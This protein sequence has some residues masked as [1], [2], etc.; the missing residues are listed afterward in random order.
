M[1]LRIQSWI[2]KLMHSFLEL[3]DKKLI[4]L[5]CIKSLSLL[6]PSAL[7]PHSNLIIPFLL[8]VPENKFEE[9]IYI[10]VSNIFTTRFYKYLIQ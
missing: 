8:V 3:T 10:E 7:I 9:D 6:Y 5:K 2:L 4:I 1:N